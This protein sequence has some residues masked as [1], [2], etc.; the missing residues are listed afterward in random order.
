MRSIFV[1]SLVIVLSCLLVAPA[2]G[3]TEDEIVAKYLKK[4]EKKK[5]KK[6]GFAVIQG[7][8]GRLNTNNTYNQFA[9]QV[10][11]MIASAVGLDARLPGIYRSKEFFAGVGL[12]ASPK[13]SVT[14][15]FNYW[16]K[17]GSNQTG[18]YNLALLNAADSLD[19]MG[20][21]LT[22]EIQVYGFSSS[23]E[24]YLTNPP[25]KDGFMT[26]LA[27]KAIVGGGYYFANWS[28][29][30]DF[31]GYNLD[32]DATTDPTTAIQ[33]KL[34]GSA[35]GFTVGFASEYP[36]G[37]AGLVV[38]GSAIYRY[39]NFSNMKWYNDSDEEIVAIYQQSGDR[40]DIDLSGPRA[41]MGFKK[42]FSW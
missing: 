28:V 24:Y 39:L 18:D 10:S 17:L 6:V 22:S 34:T 35:P 12:M 9:S 13:A 23:L 1:F 21:D 8:Y 3:Q 36:I 31:A 38:E 32:A 41:R 25:D 27:L 19:H 30:Q 33:G 40:V 42:Y 16:L 11:P 7:S 5:I 26:G 37:L 15:G 29:W 2:F 4:A 14:F 20:F